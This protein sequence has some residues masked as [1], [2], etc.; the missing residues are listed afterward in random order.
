MNGAFK[1]VFF[2]IEYVKNNLDKTYL[3]AIFYCRVRKIVS[4]L[5]WRREE[6]EFKTTFDLDDFEKIKLFDSKTR[7]AVEDIKKQ[8]GVPFENSQI[9][10]KF[11]ASKGVVLMDFSH[12]KP[13]PKAIF[14]KKY[15]VFNMF[16]KGSKTPSENPFIYINL[17][18]TPY[19]ELELKNRPRF[20]KGL[21]SFPIT[22]DA[23]MDIFD[24]E[25][26]KDKQI[27]LSADSD[28]W[29]RKKFEKDEIYLNLYLEENNP[30]IDNNKTKSDGDE[31]KVKT[32]LGE[33]K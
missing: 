1:L 18:I 2:G 29:L 8:R 23:A 26:I 15:F 28:N 31:T 10:Q 11:F 19:D 12:K 25:E 6:D 27:P 22:I 13:D 14:S 9:I 24:C 3:T 4:L 17:V 21:E 33:L 32:K 5:D 16:Y 7:K 30:S 20:G